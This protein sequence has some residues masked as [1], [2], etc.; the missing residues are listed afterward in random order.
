MSAYVTVRSLDG[1]AC[2]IDWHVGEPGMRSRRI[3]TPN[4]VEDVQAD[5]DEL[6]FI[7]AMA[8]VGGAPTIPFATN[9]KVQRWYGDHAKFI[10]DNILG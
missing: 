8:T 9:A 3:F 6:N 10:A 2:Q 1:T 5:G 7:L 4:M